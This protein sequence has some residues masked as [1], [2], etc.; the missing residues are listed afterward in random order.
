MSPSKMPRR[1]VAQLLPLLALLTL[2]P[3]ARAH[4]EPPKTAA[5]L[6]EAREQQE[7]LA[8]AGVRERRLYETRAARPETLL[9]TDTF[10]GQGR[11]V[12]QVAHDPAS[13]QRSRSSYDDAGDWVLEET[14]RQD[15]LAER[16]TFS[17][18]PDHLLEGALSEDLV[19][20]TRERLAY[21]RGADP[22]EVVVRKTSAD[23]LA[24]T[25]RFRYEPG[26]G[27]ARLLDALQTGPRGEPLLRTRQMWQ[28]GRRRTK[29]VFGPDGA[30]SYSF[31][32]DY[33]ARG[34]LLA[35][36]RRDAGG[37]IVLRQEYV[38]DADRLPVTVTD[39]GA[40]GLVT[41][42]LRYAY[43]RRAAARAGN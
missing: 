19:A 1:A 30:L 35:V 36:T 20:G 28:D 17:Y 24:Y 25:I 31:S 23:T 26:S 11:H 22:D 3:V 40:D 41:R 33:D 21:D 5:E 32:F 13:S 12:G 2:A 10:D 39:R 38:R 7:R 37:A 9:L 14:W 8:A 18:G 34:D 6:A 29:Q 43:E 15:Q 42:V 4:D 16:V 27:R